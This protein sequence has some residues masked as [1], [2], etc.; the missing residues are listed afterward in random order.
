MEK[1]KINMDAD[2][3][4]QLMFTEYKDMVSVKEC[5]EMLGCGVKKVYAMVNDGTLRSIKFKGYHIT[6]K[7]VIE[8]LLSL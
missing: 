1:V 6:K 2:T 3:A 8:Y 5:C 7:S 4:Y